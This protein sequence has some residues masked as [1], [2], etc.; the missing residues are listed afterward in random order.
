MKNALGVIFTIAA[1]FLFFAAGFLTGREYTRQEERDER[2]RAN[3]AELLEDLKKINKDIKEER[4]SIRNLSGG[5]E[6]DKPASP[7]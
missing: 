6:V 5:V 2:T 7:Y 4:K 3:A 1:L